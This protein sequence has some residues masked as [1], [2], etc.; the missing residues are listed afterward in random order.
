MLK[1]NS[2]KHLVC[3][4]SPLMLVSGMNLSQ[5]RTPTLADGEH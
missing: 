4:Y 3:M 1:Y 2:V 5:I